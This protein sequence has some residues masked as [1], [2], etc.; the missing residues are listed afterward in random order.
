MDNANEVIKF[1]RDELHFLLDLLHQKLNEDDYVAW[2]AVSKE[3]P[4]F[5]TALKNYVLRALLSDCEASA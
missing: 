2:I 1:Y 5:E 4:E 3:L